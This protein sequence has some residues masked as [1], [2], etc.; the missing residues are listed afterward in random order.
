MACEEKT[1]SGEPLP[2]CLRGF[3]AWG[4]FLRS[5]EITLDEQTIV[6]KER[7]HAPAAREGQKVSV[8]TR[9]AVIIAGFHEEPFFFSVVFFLYISLCSLC[10]VY[11]CKSGS[12]MVVLTFGERAVGPFSGACLLFHPEDWTGLRING[13]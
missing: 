1:R 13:L 8:G 6:E 10:I 7:L 3:K 9:V 11:S 12:G 4:L 2:P 5:V